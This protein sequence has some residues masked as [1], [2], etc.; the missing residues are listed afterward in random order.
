M[1]KLERIL[2]NSVPVRFVVRRSKHWVLP[3]FRGMHLYDVAVYFIS[4]VRKVGLTER[5]SAISFQFLLAIP[6]ATIFLCTLIPFMPVSQINDQLLRL[7]RDFS[8]T[9]ST[10]KMIEGFLNDFFKTTRGSLLSLGFFLA[11]YYSSNAMMGIMRT[12]NK[13]LTKTT[14]KAFFASRWMAIKLTT[15]VI[16]MVIVCAILLITQGVLTARLLKLLK[17]HDPT[18]IALIESGRWIVIVL[19]L[20]STIAF[21]YKYAPAVHKRWPLL[22]PGCLLATV[23]ILVVT[24][25]FSVWVNRFGNYNKVYGSIGTILIIMMLIYINSMILLIGFEL[26]VSIQAV[27][28]KQEEKQ[29][30]KV[31]DIL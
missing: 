6:A 10:Y 19:L 31:K 30:E 27:K 13:S 23:L 9:L 15:L 11:I 28:D 5:A 1:I 14:K 22:S 4:Q 18:T 20:V 29:R 7:A 24:Y 2:W 8:P 17:I 16:F 25:L 26:N 12:F 3:G 21:V